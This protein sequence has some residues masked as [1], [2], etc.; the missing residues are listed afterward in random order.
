[1]YRLPRPLLSCLTLLLTGVGLLGTPAAHAED[2]EPATPVGQRSTVNL[3]IDNDLFGGQGQDQGYTNGLLLTVVSPNLIDMRRDPCMPNGMQQFDR[4]LQ[5]LHPEGFEQVN[6]VFTFGHALFTP[7]NREETALI[8]DDRPYAA[9]MIFGVGYNARKGDRMSTSHLHLGWVGPSARGKET[10]D[11]VHK[12]LGVERFQGWD[13]QLRDEPAIQISHG[14]LRHYD[15]PSRHAGVQQDAITHWGA[16][17]GNL[18]THLNVGAE[19][20]IGRNLP[21]DFGSSPQN[22]AGEN[23]APPSRSIATR[24]L[25]GHFFVSVDGNWVLHDITLDGNTFKNS[26]SVKRI[27]LTAEL[28]LGISVSYKRWKFALA[29]YFRTREFEGQEVRPFYGSF[30]ISRQF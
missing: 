24:G 12:L 1:M 30:T 26:H 21:D 25:S 5:R 18:N 4:W 9:G 6:M 10:Q 20:R 17:L 3:R 29:R 19:W 8:L 7:T 22:M 2:C 28:G 14:R 11:A 13:N 15:L 23:T 27:P 16:S